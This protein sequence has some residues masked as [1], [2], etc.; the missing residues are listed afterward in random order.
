MGLAANAT[1]MSGSA[2]D[3]IC[4]HARAVHADLIV[5]MSHGRTGIARAWM[6]G[7]ADA[8]VRNSDVPV[9]MLREPARDDW[10]AAAHQ[11]FG[12]ILVPLDGSDESSAILR[13]AAALARCAG[14]S[15]TLVRVVRPLSVSLPDSALPSL[16][17]DDI[18]DADAL[19]DLVDDAQRQLGDASSR[20]L[21]FGANDV[22]TKVVVAKRVAAMVLALATKHSANLIAMSTHGRGASR[23]LI[24][25]VA[26]RVISGTSLPLLLYHPRGRTAGGVLEARRPSEPLPVLAPV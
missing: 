7:V 11:L 2:A 26:D 4:R 22:T 23:L 24:G 20:L 15:I 6:G 5:M 17:P 16:N 9:L 8:V 25:S 3:V 12:R 10:R 13:P 21:E 14:S 18:A 19:Q 1:T